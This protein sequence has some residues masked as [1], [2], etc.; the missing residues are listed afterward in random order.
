V[1][2]GRADVIRNSRLTAFPAHRGSKHRVL[3]QSS[4]V[5]LS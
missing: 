5:S 2:R 1:V 3:L 4:H